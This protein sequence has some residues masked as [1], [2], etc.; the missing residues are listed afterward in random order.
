[1]VLEHDVEEAEILDFRESPGK[2]LRCRL[3]VVV[4]DFQ[5]LDLQ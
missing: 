1:M 2:E 3:E 5:E 4:L